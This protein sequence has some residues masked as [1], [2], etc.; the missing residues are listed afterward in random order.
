MINESNSK[1]Y[2]IS[3]YDQRDYGSD[4]SSVEVSKSDVGV[5]TYSCSAGDGSTGAGAV[6]AL[7]AMVTPVG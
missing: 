3:N 6:G 2:C 1:R 5:D 7:P 4:M